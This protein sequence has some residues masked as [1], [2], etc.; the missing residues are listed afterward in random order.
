MENRINEIKVSYYGGDHIKKAPKIKL[1]ADAAEI[2]FF[3]WDKGVLGLQETFKV[4]L[5]D[6]SNRVKGQY[7]LSKGGIHGTLVDIRILMAVALKSLSVGLILAHNHPSGN[8][9][10]SSADRE[11]TSKIIK[12]ASYFD[13]KILDHLILAP[14]GDYY[15]FADQGILY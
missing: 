7:E 10:P 5:L 6:R 14:N 1:S 3:Q 9:S 13:I 2:L 15:S 4:L 11:T 8:L 12:A